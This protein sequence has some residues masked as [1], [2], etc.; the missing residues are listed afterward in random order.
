LQGG[1]VP[2]V[3]VPLNRDTVYAMFFEGEDIVLQYAIEALQ[4]P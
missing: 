2:D 1:V 4:A 3:H